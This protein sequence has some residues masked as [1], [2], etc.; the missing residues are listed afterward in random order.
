MYTLFL[1]YNSGLSY[2]F[3]CPWKYQT[4][5]R[6]DMLLCNDGFSCDGEIDGYT[7]CN[8]HLGRSLCPNNLPVMCNAR[9]CATSEKHPTGDYC[10]QKSEEFCKALYG[11]GERQC[12]LDTSLSHSNEYF[13]PWMHDAAL[14]EDLIKCVDG[15]L[16]D[17]INDPLGHGCCKNHG[18]IS[19]CP[20]TH[21]VM[22]D[23]PICANG[24]DY[25]C[26]GSSNECV[27]KYNTTTRP[28][29]KFKQGN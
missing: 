22:C 2:A 25:C 17:G 10:C 28:C 3:E 18:G 27:T 6:N 8:D 12:N 11:V 26:V 7:C 13:C 16:C 29:E 14:R 9:R 4:T 5:K 19:V 21:R 1:I 24:T 23:K 20:G 15:Y